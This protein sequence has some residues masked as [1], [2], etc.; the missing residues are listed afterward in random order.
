MNKNR[1]IL[2]IEPVVNDGLKFPSCVGVRIRIDHKWTGHSLRGEME[3][4]AWD[5]GEDL[6]IF[7]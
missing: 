6:E 3:S 5:F 7:I 1:I 2:L 4:L